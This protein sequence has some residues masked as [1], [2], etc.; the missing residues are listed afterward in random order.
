MSWFTKILG[1]EKE[2]KEE[3]VLVDKPK[4][5]TNTPAIPVDNLPSQRVSIPNITSQVSSLNSIYGV[6]LPDFPVEVIPL[7]R[8][9]CKFNDSFGLAL[10]DLV[11]L[12]NTG[13]KITF[14][15]SVPPEQVDLMRRHINAKSRDWVSGCIGLHGI[16]NKI[17]SQIYI[18]GAI[19]IEGVPTR[20]LNGIKYLAFVNPED[21]VFKYHK[22]NCK[23]EAYQRVMTI[24]NTKNQGLTKLNPTSYKYVQLNGDGEVPYGYPPLLTALEDLAVSK[25]MDANIQFI[26]KQFGL[27]GFLEL[28]ISKPSAMGGES[29]AAYKVRL[30]SLL[31]ESK[32]ALKEGLKDGVSVG[33]DEDHKYTFNSTTKNMGNIPDVYDMAQRNLSNG[34]KYPG[35][36]MGLSNKTE[37]NI[38]IIFTKMLSQ[39][40]NIQRLVASVLEYFIS[41]ELY[42]AGFKFN[43]MTFSFEASTIT[44]GLKIQQSDEI[45]IRNLQAKYDQGIISQETF[46]DELGYEA[47]DQKEPRVS[48]ETPG[49]VD[50]MV[51]AKKKK[52]RES[53]KDKSDRKV[54][55]KNNPQPKRKDSSTKTV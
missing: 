23:Y 21:I 39:L 20:D 47:P 10:Q 53:D 44:D 29:D 48:R 17:I 22:S 28:L 18:S 37:T 25:D 45:K 6:E 30:E 9:L 26:M 8:R 55:D 16:V 12:T 19:S 13:H 11:Q 2:E 32:K 52:D 50:P 36:F 15:R 24:N 1:I 33:F 49:S 46:A 4:S 40:S 51:D 31:T 34:L 7:I 43:Y 5:K 27:M 38:T 42:L 3:I 41:M 54:R 14:D 35:A